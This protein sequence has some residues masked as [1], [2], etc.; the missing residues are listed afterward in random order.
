[1]TLQEIMALHLV[2]L[3]FARD[4]A[5]RICVA[6]TAAPWLTPELRGR[7]QALAAAG[8]FVALEAMLARSVW[9]YSG[10][11]GGVARN[12]GVDFLLRDTCAELGPAAANGVLQRALGVAVDGRLSAEV[13][14]VLAGAEVEP[15]PL[16]RALDAARRAAGSD[17]GRARAAVRLAQAFAPRATAR[18]LTAVAAG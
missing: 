5:G 8:E 15:A 16:L 18:P 14:A 17:A 3:A 10:K 1:M 12:A 13:R 9:R 7:A 4:R 11:L 2:N 6:G